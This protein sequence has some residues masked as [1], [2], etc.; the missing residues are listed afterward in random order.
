MSLYT[1][2]QRVSQTVFIIGILCLTL[3]LRH[4]VAHAKP[5]AFGTELTKKAVAI[6]LDTRVAEPKAAAIHLQPAK[7]KKGYWQLPGGTDQQN[8]AL[9]I[10]QDAL[11]ARGVTDP[12]ALKYGSALLV[13]ENEK[14]T[15]DRISFTGFD[16]GLCQMNTGKVPSRIFMKQHPEWLDVKKQANW[17][18]DRFVQ[19]YDKYHQDIFRAVVQNHCPACARKGKDSTSFRWHGKSVPLIPPYFQR[20]KITSAKLSLL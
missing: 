1:F 18:A 9:R 6:Q 11:K 5:L 3:W 13:H 16:F 10:Y 12:E 14:L 4:E 20:V 17:C 19:T 7:S 8:K 15:V 2:Y